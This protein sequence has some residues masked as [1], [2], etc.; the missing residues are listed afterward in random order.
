MISP[1]LTTNDSVEIK[2]FQN[3]GGITLDITG[4]KHIVLLS[5]LH[6]PQKSKEQFGL[7]LMMEMYS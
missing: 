3:T 2:A 1:D 5:Q 6:L 7:A 4:A